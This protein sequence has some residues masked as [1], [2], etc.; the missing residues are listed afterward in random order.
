M[1]HHPHPPELRALCIQAAGLFEALPAQ[2]METRSETLVQLEALLSRID[3][4]VKELDLRD[5]DFPR[6]Q[7]W[8]VDAASALRSIEMDRGGWNVEKFA[9]RAAEDLRRVAEG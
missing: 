5:P 7:G 4:Q 9:H 3:E 1:T 8:L 6:E 2:E